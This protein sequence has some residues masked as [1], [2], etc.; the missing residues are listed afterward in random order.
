[1]TRDPAIT[2][3]ILAEQARQIRLE[4]QCRD[5]FVKQLGEGYPQPRAK[6][7]GSAY[8]LLRRKWTHPQVSEFIAAYTAGNISFPGVLDPPGEIGLYEFMACIGILAEGEYART[9][10][11]KEMLELLAGAD[12][13]RGATVLEA[14]GC[15]GRMS[16]AARS[17]A[18][19]DEEMA[20]EYLRLRGQPGN[21]SATALKEAIGKKR[22]L[23][24][25]A[26]M[27]AVDRGLKK[28]GS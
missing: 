6:A 5:E 1:V 12:A 8:C 9:L 3:E 24:R 26:A 15:G 2:D 16:A 14:A 23:G 10:P 4:R 19:R 18:A 17:T 13:V 28:V 25:R 7:E 22:G 21:K 20:K 27:A 11:R